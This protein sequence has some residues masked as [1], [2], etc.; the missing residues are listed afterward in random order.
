[1]KLY[2]GILRPGKILSVEPQGIIRASAPGLFS[3][4]DKDKL[5]PVYPFYGICSN[6]ANTYSSPVVGDEV[7]VLNF[8]DNPRQLY[9]F[10]KDKY[11]DINSDILGDGNV[12]ILCNRKLDG[13]NAS[14]YFTDGTG[15]MFSLGGSFINMTS[16]GNIIIKSNDGKI[17]DVNSGISLGSEG[18]SSHSACYAD[19]CIKVFNNIADILS[20]VQT[21]AM[22]SPYT[23]NIGN[24]LSG[25]SNTIKSSAKNI[26]ST[27][28]TLD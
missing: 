26:E 8:S 12:E 25:A 3:E 2:H 15:W 17:L 28:V 11:T 22:G 9:W 13:G 4:E 1:M 27:V 20:K 10:R 16:N 5:P 7:W 18:Q 23:T 19:E 6:H 24:A 21:A 14:I